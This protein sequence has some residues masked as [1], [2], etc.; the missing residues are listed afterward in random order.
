MKNIILI[1]LLLTSGCTT[2]KLVPVYQEFNPAAILMQPPH[3][4]ETIKVQPP[5]VKPK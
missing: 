1:L 3:H 5:E 4:H 2:V